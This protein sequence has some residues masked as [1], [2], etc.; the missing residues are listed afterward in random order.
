MDISNI[1]LL[2]APFLSDKEKIRLIISCK[3]SYQRK[4]SLRFSEYHDHNLIYD[5]FILYQINRIILSNVIDLHPNQKNQIKIFFKKSIPNSVNQLDG[6]IMWFSMFNH[7]LIEI[8]LIISKNNIQSFYNFI[9]WSVK[10]GNIFILKELL[11]LTMELK[12][13][14][15]DAINE[16]LFLAR[17]RGDFFMTK[18]LLS[19]GADDDYV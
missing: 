3:T 12:T 5:N 7:K 14:I 2:I 18:L 17:E 4:R 11:F 15:K 6:E 10:Y 9:C 8:K 1:C 19:Y 16:A 13:I